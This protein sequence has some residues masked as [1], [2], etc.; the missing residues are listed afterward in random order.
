M[1]FKLIDLFHDKHDLG[2]DKITSMKTTAFSPIEKLTLISKLVCPSVIK[3][4]L[5]SNDQF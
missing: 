3:S 5:K 1:L 2:N 4:G